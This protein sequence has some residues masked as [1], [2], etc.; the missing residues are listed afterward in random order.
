M[1]L[2]SLGSKLKDSLAK[3]AK[4]MFVDDKLINEL[5]K[6]IQRALLSADVNVSL[7]LE[8]TKSIKKR[9][10]DDK[11]PKGLTQKEYLVRIVYEELVKFLGEEKT[12]IKIDKSKKPYK[13]MMVGLFGSGKTTQCGKLAK[14]YVKRGYKVGL[15]G[16]DVWRPAAADQLSQL[17]KQVGVDVFVDRKEKDPIK[18]YDQYKE[19][20]KDY[21]ILL[22]DTAGRDALSE[23][24]IEEIEKISKKVKAHERLLVLS[25]DIGQTAQKQAEQ[26]H[27]S[28][29]VTGII[30]TKLDGTAKGGGA[31]VATAATDAKILFTISLSIF[32]SC[33]RNACI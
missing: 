7:V 25:A 17:A 16:L 15:L 4:A 24:L 2:D 31:L 12:E 5:C 14:Y 21:D 26:F 20:Y 3:I 22:I 23:E 1:V 13:I 6:D 9:A 27:K 30:A 11:L 29:N 33:S 8:L 18:I 32:S 28:C 19:L 10:K